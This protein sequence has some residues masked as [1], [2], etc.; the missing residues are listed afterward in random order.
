MAGPASEHN[1]RRL[2]DCLFAGIR[3]AAWTQIDLTLLCELDI[4]GTKNKELPLAG[5][6]AAV[7]I[8]WFTWLAV[9]AFVIW[10]GWKLQGEM[11]YYDYPFFVYP[12]VFTYIPLALVVLDV[13]FLW[14]LPHVEP[15]R[16]SNR[17]CR[18]VVAGLTLVTAS[19]L[20]TAGLHHARSQRGHEID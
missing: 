11:R 13:L 19:V 7:L 14:R 8:L 16:R 17:T 6:F 12:I 5:Q 18:F 15:V 9:L 20:L 4:I 10:R 3:S 2:S 1:V